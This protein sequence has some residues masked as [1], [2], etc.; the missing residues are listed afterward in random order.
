MTLA[1]VPL[2]SIPP[3]AENGGLLELG[4]A[5][6]FISRLGQ[7]G[8]VRVLPLSATERLRGADDPA[9]AAKRM[10]ATHVLTGALQR[11]RSRVRATVHLTAIADSRVLWSVPV[12]TDSSSLFSIQDIIVSRVIEEVAPGAAAGT[13]RRLAQPGTF[14]NAAY[15]EYLRGRALV[16][17]LTRPELTRAMNHFREAVRLDGRYAD[18]WAGLASASRRMPLFDVPPAEGFLETK[19]AALRALALEPSH[20]EAQLALGVVTFWFDWDYP[21]A[22]AQLR[23]ALDLQPSST[24]AA[25]S[26]AHLLSN[27]G[28]HDEAL[29]E[30]RRARASDPAWPIP[31]SLEGQF[32][33][34][35]RRHEDALIGLTELEAA[36]PRLPAVRIMRAYPL[37][38]L[39]RYEEAVLECER[40]LEINRHLGA[41]RPHSFTLALRGYALAR[42][43]RIAEANEAL[44]ALRRQAEHQ[45]VPPHHEALLLH[46]L[47][48]D[49]EAVRRL[50]DALGVR[51]FFVTFLGVD[52]KWDALRDL[53][54]FRRVLSQAHLLDVSD[55]QPR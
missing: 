11:E 42:T 36:E 14:S 10:G 3:D 22:E 49:D 44:A 39:G 12:D 33:Y 48:R 35:A 53:P 43:K 1:V 30:I 6:V 21:R 31:R 13:R 47:G 8:G 20:A 25:L 27:L 17:R 9:T 2:R 54:P 16:G 4:L 51:D 18:A 37:I 5:D 34:M 52:P 46:A 19:R 55:R 15:E 29:V 50:Q 40:A 41:D 23:Q 38:A 24:D 26:L 7:L 45:Y 28:R 32:L